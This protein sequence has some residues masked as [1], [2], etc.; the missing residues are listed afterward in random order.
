MSLQNPNITKEDAGFIYVDNVR[1]VGAEIPEPLAN[2]V[3]VSFHEADDAPTANA[4]DAGFAE[5]PD[6]GYT[7]LLNDSGYNVTRYLT[8]ATPDVNILN[9]ADLVI[10]SRST[11]STGYQNDGAT[12]WSSSVT[13]PMIIMHGWTLRSSRMGYTTG[14]TME[15]ITGEITLT[16]NNPDHPIFAGISLTDGTMDNPYAGLA[17]YPDGETVALGISLNTDPIDDEG[18]VLATISEAG[19]GPV[20]GMVIGEWKAGATLNHSGGAETDVL[21]GHRM[22]FL[23]GSREPSGVHSDTAG[24]Y[25]LSEDGTQ[26]FLN[27][28]DYM[29]PPEPVNPGADG[30]VAYYKLDGDAKDSSG[31]ALDG[32]IIGDPNFVKGQMGLALQLEGAGDYIDCGADPLFGMQETN[33]M[34]AACWVTIRS[35]ANQWA[36]IVAK[37]EHAWRLGN[38]SFDPRFH[39]GIS[40]WNA[41]DTPSVDGITAVGLDEW[42]HVAGV[43]GGGDIMI[44]LDGAYEASA[45]TTE[46]IGTNDLNVFIG[47]NPEA[48]GRYWDGL[49]DE[50]YIY[51][52]AL[53]A[54]ELMY[55]AQ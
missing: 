13:T 37:G 40:I 31:N 36:A 27:A 42:H 24:M 29:V 54:E 46:P 23:T 10:I 6:K 30:L 47:D 45:P 7:D 32:T 21:A 28:V 12:T 52:R 35:I 4:A 2:I 17:T 8:T 18:I 43:Y 49:V 15:D 3:F 22:V 25:D 41:P 53:S 1:V 20:G 50:V 48:T 33:E 55:L 39:F 34:T 44:Y 26:M 19:N 14:T 16:T 11:G 9:A 51:N 5:A 38:V